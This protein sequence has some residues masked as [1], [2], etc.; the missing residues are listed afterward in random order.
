MNKNQ[1]LPI[2]GLLGRI[3]HKM[4]LILG[5]ALIKHD[6]SLNVEQFLVL[7]CLSFNDGIKQQELSNI[8]NRDKT[9]ITRIISKMEKKN[10]VLRIHSKDDKRVNNVHLTNLGKEML[11][12]IN[13]LIN[14]INTR[15]TKSIS[16]VEYD[17]LKSTIN[18][19]TMQIEEIEKTL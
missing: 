6:I 9:T 4:Q 12:T 11:I 7:K 17:R 19:L 16:A 14:S 13:P 1:E 8:I 18:K 2:G 5:K 15:L 10:L 3:S